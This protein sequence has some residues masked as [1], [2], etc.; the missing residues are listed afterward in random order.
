MNGVVDE[1]LINENSFPLECKITS[2]KRVY[3]GHCISTPSRD[4]DASDVS[5]W[6]IY[7]PNTTV[8]IADASNSIVS[9]YSIDIADVLGI[10][11][12]GIED[13]VFS[14]D[15]YANY[16]CE[17]GSI[18]DETT[19]LHCVTSSALFDSYSFVFSPPSHSDNTIRLKK[20]GIN[21]KV[22]PNEED[23]TTYTVSGTLWGYIAEA[24]GVIL[25]ILLMVGSKEGKNDIPPNVYYFVGLLGIAIL[26]GNVIRLY[27]IVCEVKWLLGADINDDEWDGVSEFLD[28]HTLCDVFAFLAFIILFIVLSVNYSGDENGPEAKIKFGGFLFLVGAWALSIIIFLPELDAGSG[29]EDNTG[30]T[31][32]YYAHEYYPYDRFWFIRVFCLPVA[33]SFGGFGFGIVISYRMIG[34][35]IPNCNNCSFSVFVT[36]V[37]L[38]I[39]IIG[40]QLSSVEPDEDGNPKWTFYLYG[41]LAAFAIGLGLMVCGCCGAKKSKSGSGGIQ[42]TPSRK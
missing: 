39:S 21:P 20:M 35:D 31:S 2:S 38:T 32:E 17:P 13:T 24:S 10:D 36:C 25:L 7:D 19:S 27:L 1:S 16:G 26:M 22:G 28:N 9:D 40:A 12:L 33:V 11:S 30:W 3:I 4:C 15:F 6:T 23:Y 34:N 8:N 41:G 14:V 18:E 5:S 29:S 37:G 42:M